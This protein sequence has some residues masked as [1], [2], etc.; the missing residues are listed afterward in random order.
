MEL[1]DKLLSRLK[2]GNRPSMKSVDAD[3]LLEV[4]RIAGIVQAA[5]TDWGDAR[6]TRAYNPWNRTIDW[7]DDHYPDWRGWRVEYPQRRDAA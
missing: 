3:A 2:I 1:S 7:L 5:V 6:F 4:A